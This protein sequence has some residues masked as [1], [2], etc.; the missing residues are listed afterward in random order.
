MSQLLLA[1]QLLIELKSI[2]VTLVV[3]FKEAG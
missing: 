3:H 2:L 1:R